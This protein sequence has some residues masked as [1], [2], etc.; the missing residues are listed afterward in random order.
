MSYTQIHK[1]KIKQKIRRK[2]DIL[3]MRNKENKR[4]IPFHDLPGKWTQAAGVYVYVYVSQF[5]PA[6]SPVTKF[7]EDKK[8]Q[9]QMLHWLKC[10]PLCV[11][12]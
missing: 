3:G 12:V 7:V 4:N 10:G 8:K 11:C 9:E 6:Q 5:A 2:V 1:I